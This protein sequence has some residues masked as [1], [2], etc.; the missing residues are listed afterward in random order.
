MIAYICSDQVLHSYISALGIHCPRLA[1]A[2]LLAD[3]PSLRHGD[4]TVLTAAY[5]RARLRG[6]RDPLPE[7]TF[8]EVC[9]WT[10]AQ[11]LDDTFWPDK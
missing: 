4:V 11:V 6:Q 1:I 10:F 7:A 5:Q 8:P 2:D 9:P 3:S